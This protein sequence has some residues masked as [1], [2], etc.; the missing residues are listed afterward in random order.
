MVDKLVE[1]VNKRTKIE[2]WAREYLE[3]NSAL[4]DDVK[5]NHPVYR[6][7]NSKMNE[8]QTICDNIRSIEYARRKTT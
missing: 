8:Y 4:M 6:E 7:Y 5:Y 1:L 2:V 3:E